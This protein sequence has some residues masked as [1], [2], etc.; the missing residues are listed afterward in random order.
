MR[1]P[2]ALALPLVLAL[3]ACG[4][5]DSP[6]IDVPAL[7]ARTI[8]ASGEAESYRVSAK[9]ESDL[10]GKRV[11]IEAEG[12]SA[13]DQSRGRY[14]GV[15]VEDGQRV[16]M[17]MIVAE[18]AL[19]FSG[20]DFAAALPPEKTW[21]RMPDDTPRTMTPAEFVEF[22]READ[23]VE[24]V[25]REQIRGVS[26]I[27]LRGPLDIGELVEDTSSEA[28]RYFSRLPGAD[29]FDATIDAWISEEDDRITRMALLLTY[30]DTSGSMS[31]T[32]D[33]LKY[34]VSLEGVEPPDPATIADG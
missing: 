25:G 30:P 28:A 12:V 4:A 27:H 34:D 33:V 20:K 19:Y 24:N 22:L 16:R 1:S 26:N 29:E 14:D 7:V 8:T 23:D 6:G 10:G 15:Y 9:V 5:G 3:G 18:G 13:A 21:L 11:R 2:V 31:M 32:A 17:D